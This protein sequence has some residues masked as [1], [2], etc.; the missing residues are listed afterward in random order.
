MSKF[1]L[2]VNLSPQTGAFLRETF[3]FDVVRSTPPELPDEA[4][5]ALAKREQRVIIT[6]DQDFGEI[7]YLSERGRIGVL[8]L[9]L[10]D[11]TI[12]SVNRV[13]AA[14]LQTQAHDID[15]DTS[16]VVLEEQQVRVVRA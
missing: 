4:V 8:V 15:L 7:Y 6:L 13:L 10:R 16:L 1:L 11:Q 3:G 2:D 14:F 12:E 5:V 9:R